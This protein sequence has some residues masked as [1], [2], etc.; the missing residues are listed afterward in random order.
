MSKQ[1]LPKSKRF[2]VIFGNV[3][4]FGFVAIHRYHIF[5]IWQLNCCTIYKKYVDVSTHYNKTGEKICIY[6][7]DLWLW[8]RTNKICGFINFCGPNFYNL[9][10][11]SRV[12]NGSK[13]KLCYKH[14]L[15][16]IKWLKFKYF[17]NIL[18]IQDNDQR[19]VFE[20]FTNIVTVQLFSLPKVTIYF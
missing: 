12:C 4:Y 15:H 19:T 7:I 18:L 10:S 17:F 5:N 13:F 2:S 1:L 6:R 20:S 8:I 11:Y 16:A 9:H 14:E 3:K